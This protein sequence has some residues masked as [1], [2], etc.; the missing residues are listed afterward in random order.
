[1]SCFFNLSYSNL[2]ANRGNVAVK[3]CF[4]LASPEPY[5]TL[6][7][8]E[9]SLKLLNTRVVEYLFAVAEHAMRP[10]WPVVFRVWQI[11]KC[12]LQDSAFMSYHMR[13]QK[14]QNW[15]AESGHHQEER[16]R[17][18]QNFN[19]KED[20]PMPCT[21]DKMGWLAI[22]ISPRIGCWLSIYGWWH[23]K[24]RGQE[25]TGVCYTPQPG[26]R[27]HLFQK[28]T[29][30]PDNLHFRRSKDSDMLHCKTFCKHV[31]Y[32]KAIPVEE[33]SR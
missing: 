3:Y 9:R 30:S 13:T 19:L 5:I 29:Q 12:R 21:G 1:M 20:R 32:V 2:Y 33:I 25:I 16:W 6:A 31:T 17:G 11:C 8:R 4:S 24:Y 26:Q 23:N 18:G 27:Q 7:G 28:V 14:S 22:L 15:S 10:P